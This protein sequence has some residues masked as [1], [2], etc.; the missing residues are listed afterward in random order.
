MYA[1]I[2]MDFQQYEIDV[3]LQFRF[4]LQVLFLVDWLQFL[5]TSTLSLC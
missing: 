4:V 1:I 2:L 3:F 5:I